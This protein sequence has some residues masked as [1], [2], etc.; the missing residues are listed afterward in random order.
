[1]WSWVLAST[2][3]L[4]PAEKTRRGSLAPTAIRSERASRPRSGLSFQAQEQRSTHGGDGRRSSGPS[5]RPIPFPAHHSSV[6]RKLPSGI[7]T[8]LFTDVEGSTRLLHE[9]GADAYARA[10]SGHRRILR[11]AA[12]AHGGTEVNTQGDSFLIAFARATDAVA[13]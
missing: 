7:V 11:E 12:R 10:L 2:R 1:M 8:F 4:V 13:A 6:R 9:L 5:L 3:L